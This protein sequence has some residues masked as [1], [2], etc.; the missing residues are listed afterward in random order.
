MIKGVKEIKYQVESFLYRMSEGREASPRLDNISFRTKTE[1]AKNY[2]VPIFIGN[3]TIRKG[4]YWY[5]EEPD[6]EYLKRL[7]DNGHLFSNKSHINLHG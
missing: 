7:I 6:S 1:S 3:P 4:K 2:Y 5:S